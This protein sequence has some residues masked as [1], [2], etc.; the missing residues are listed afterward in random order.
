[1]RIAISGAQCTGKSTLIA[2]FLKAYPTYKQSKNDYRKLIKQKKLSINTQGTQ[3]SQEIILNSMLD[4]CMN[5]KSTDHVIF[6]RCTLD[7]IVYSLWLKEKYPDSIDEMFI[8][9]SI[10]LNKQACKFYDI[11]F[12]TPITKYDTI[13]LESKENR[14]V[15]PVYRNEINNIFQAIMKGYHEQKTGIFDMRDV[16]AFIEVF[17]S[18]DERI[19]MIK[20]YINPE[21]GNQ[22]DEDD[23]LITKSL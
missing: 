5:Y 16:P 7:N 9:K 10:E 6:D 8:R 22:Y 2:D 21:T 15:D 17:G 12:F 18:R 20:F 11:I 1:M 13:Q 19:Q 4:E 14:D 3:E 23:N